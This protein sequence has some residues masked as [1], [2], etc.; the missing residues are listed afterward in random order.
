M[1]QLETPVVFMVFNRPQPTRCVFAA[2]AKARPSRLLLIADGP[3]FDRPGEAE[4]CDAVRRIVSGVD[5]PCKVDTNFA[6]DNMGCRARVVSGLN[7]AFSLV[8]EAIILED[9][10]LPDQSFFQYCTELLERYRENPKIGVIS[11]FNFEGSFRHSSSYYFNSLMSIW[12]WATWRRSWQ[13][14]DE[15]MKGWPEA[16]RSGLLK[17]LFPSRR[18]VAYWENMFGRMYDGTGPNT[19]DYQWIFTS[20]NQNW[21]NVLPTT[22]LIRN[23]GFGLDATHTKK[24]DP[25]AAVRADA[26]TFPMR[27]PFAITPWHARAMKLQK[28]VF[29]RSLFLQ[30]RRKILKTLRLTQANG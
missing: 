16:K 5:W 1:N 29:A 25:L 28:N 18:I 8:E 17:R 20:W 15:H 19:W 27:H 30:I 13:H 7:W 3:R 22:N 2:I 11:G 21:L 14:Y 23:I 6:A 24:S 10:C 26:M 12:G 9:D 4:R